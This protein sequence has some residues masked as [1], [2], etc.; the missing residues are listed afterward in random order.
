MEELT[1]EDLEPTHQSLDEAIQDTVV[2][3]NEKKYEKEG[4]RAHEGRV[5][6]SV[7]PQEL[8][9]YVCYERFVISQHPEHGW[10]IH[11]GY[12]SDRKWLPDPC[13]SAVLSELTEFLD[14]DIRDLLDLY[15]EET[16]NGPI[17][18]LSPA[19][20]NPVPRSG[21]VRYFGPPG[22]DDYLDDWA[23]QRMYRVVYEMLQ[24]TSE[25]P[26]TSL[27]R[28]ALKHEPDHEEL[29]DLLYQR[30][31]QEINPNPKMSSL[32]ERKLRLL[33]FAPQRNGE[34]DKIIQE[35]VRRHSKV[36]ELEEAKRVLNAYL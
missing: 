16:G 31:T 28:K 2:N 34:L 13:Y 24:D 32:S 27:L 22:W 5:V 36:G 3:G 26:S 8:D 10:D 6:I 4:V 17:V 19:G 14:E 15:A 18:V 12:S 21:K 11:R 20:E 30:A 33:R 7:G 35:F 23:N 9:I 1:T 29:M 25:V